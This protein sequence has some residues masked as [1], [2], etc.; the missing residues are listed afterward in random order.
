M[1]RNVYLPKVINGSNSNGNWELTMM[2]AAIGIAVFLEDRAAYDQAMTK[3]RGRVPAY[4]YLTSDGALPKAP[5]GSG[6]T[7]G[8]DHQLLAGPD[9]PSSTA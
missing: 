4:I 8:R 1:L 6:S 3:F 5:P 9:A 7:P 2:E